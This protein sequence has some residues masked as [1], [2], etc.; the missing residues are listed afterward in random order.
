MRN[1]NV[2]TIVNTGLRNTQKKE[3]EKRR[4]SIVWIE[5]APANESESRHLLYYE[6]KLQDQLFVELLCSFYSRGNYVILRH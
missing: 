4:A 1:F 2:C 6:R 3:G 5:Q